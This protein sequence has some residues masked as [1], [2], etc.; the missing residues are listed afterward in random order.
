MAG[1]KSNK[2]KRFEYLDSLRGIAILLVIVYHAG[3]ITGYKTFEFFPQIY[4]DINNTFQYGVQLFFVVSAFTLMLS[5]DNRK[6]EKHATAKFFIRRF[7]RIAPMWYIAIAYT[8]LILL[9]FN[10]G[11]FDWS[12]FPK[13]AFLGDVFF[14]NSIVPSTINGFVQGGWSI[15]NEFLFYFCMPFICSRIKSLNGFITFSVLTI[16]LCSVLLLVLK[17]TA[18]DTNNYLLYY[19]FNQLPVF[20]LGLLAYW[21]GKQGGVEEVKPKVLLLLV[22]GVCFFTVADFPFPIL[23]SI[24]FFLLILMLGKKP[25]KAFSNKVFA[26]IGEVSFSMYLMHFLVM[27]FMDW[28]GYHSFLTNIIDLPSAI[29][30]YSITILLLFIPSFLVS[31]VTYKYIERKGQDIGKAIINRMK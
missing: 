20:S 4:L 15:S 29:F 12:T 21:V 9:D 14:F 11:N 30:Y 31:C 28:Y 27:Y 3:N 10:L 17:G 18:V 19:F 7:F 1:T 26:K 25:Y 6:E 5:Y 16:V 8:T 23:V 13:K 22:A 24:V 2:I